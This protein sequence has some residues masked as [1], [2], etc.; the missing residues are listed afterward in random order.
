[1]MDGPGYMDCANRP[2]SLMPRYTRPDS[3]TLDTDRPGCDRGEPHKNDG[4]RAF[5]R[6]SQEVARGL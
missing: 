3:R 5:H 1:M 2:V 6:E 4:Q